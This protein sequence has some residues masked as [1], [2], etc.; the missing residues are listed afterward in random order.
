MKFA[1][2]QTGGAID[3]GS[4]V[5]GG[6][7][8]MRPRAVNGPTQDLWIDAGRDRGWRSGAF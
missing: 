7:M 1:A 4:T 8:A 6:V 3:G 5:E 2:A